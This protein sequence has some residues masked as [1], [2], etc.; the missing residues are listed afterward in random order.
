M[1]CFMCFSFSLGWTFRS[2]PDLGSGGFFLFSLIF[3]VIVCTL[4]DLFRRNVLRQGV[5][6]FRDATLAQAI[7][8]REQPFPYL[9]LAVVKSLSSLE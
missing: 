4:F 6:M 9:F 8:E 3:K 2:P 5:D 7:S 1:C